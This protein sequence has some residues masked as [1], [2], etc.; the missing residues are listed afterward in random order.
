MARWD[1]EPRQ[2]DKLKVWKAAQREAFRPSDTQ[3]VRLCGSSAGSDAGATSETFADEMV[4]FS[5]VSDNLK[6]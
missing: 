2:W 5:K 4:V 3:S 1:S 6:L